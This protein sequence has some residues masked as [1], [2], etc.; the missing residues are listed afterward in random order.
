MA[1]E[2]EALEEI[3]A[4]CKHRWAA[5][6]EDWRQCHEYC[7]YAKGEVY[8]KI[9]RMC[10]KALGQNFNPNDYKGYEYDEYDD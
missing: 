3:L 4:Y 5:S 2:R 6:D 10:S 1:N 9:I 7:S 8:V